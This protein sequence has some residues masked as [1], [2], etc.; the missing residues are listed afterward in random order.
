MPPCSYHA[1][2][3]GPDDSKT[4][5]FGPV[6]AGPKER[7][8]TA[9]SGSPRSNIVTAVKGSSLHGAPTS[10]FTLTMYC[11]RRNKQE[12]FS[13]FRALIYCV[14]V[15]VWQTVLPFIALVP[16]RG[17]G[18][19]GS[20]SC[21]VRGG[22]VPARRRTVDRPDSIA[23]HRRADKEDCPS[24]P[25]RRAGRRA[26]SAR[27]GRRADRCCQPPGQ[28][29]RRQTSGFRGLGRKRRFRR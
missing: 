29:A 5:G 4:R 14:S 13:S 26:M 20:M 25:G 10:R 15:P 24:C 2:E 22:L 1:E 3:Y 21:W 8:Q 12:M 27:S 7:L 23:L 18:L 17:S 16:R 11:P 19:P 6:R 28:Q 9:V